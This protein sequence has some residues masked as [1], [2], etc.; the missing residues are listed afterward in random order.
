[1]S[2]IGKWFLIRCPPVAPALWSSNNGRKENLKIF[3]VL[4]RLICEGHWL[5]NSI[6]SDEQDLANYLHRL[7]LELQSQVISDAVSKYEIVIQT[8]GA[9]DFISFINNFV[10]FLEN[11]KGKTSQIRHHS[12]ISLS[13]FDDF[14]RFELHP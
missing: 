5:Q 14:L 4:R 10:V 13:L 2:S 1:M 8:K 6:E 7:R 9:P 11:L 3:C 12:W